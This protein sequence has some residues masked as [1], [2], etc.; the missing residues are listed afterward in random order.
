MKIRRYYEIA[1]RQSDRTIVPV[2]F[3]TA[4]TS[5]V[6]SMYSIFRKGKWSEGEWKATGEGDP[7]TK[8]TSLFRNLRGGNRNERNVSV[9]KR[10]RVLDRTI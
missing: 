7:F 6:I 4:T 3:A 1:K 8:K 2:F 5:K 9:K 10:L